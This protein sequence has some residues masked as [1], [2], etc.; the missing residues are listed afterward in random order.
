MESISQLGIMA[1]VGF[2]MSPAQKKELLN[3]I[4]ISMSQKAYWE[5]DREFPHSSI[6]E[7]D[8]SVYESYFLFLDDIWEKIN[9]ESES[10][11]VFSPLKSAIDDLNR[12]ATPLFFVGKGA[13][14]GQREMLMEKIAHYRIDLNA[15]KKSV[16]GAS[17]YKACDDGSESS[18]LHSFATITSLSTLAYSEMSRTNSPFEDDSDLDYSEGCGLD[19][20]EET[21]HSTNSV[22][23]VSRF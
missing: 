1:L 17:L 16:M 22:E 3:S 15:P 6:L 7:S 19:S 14:A 18:S 23:N 11:S 5:D 20:G 10:E 13:N 8:A 12:I 9:N 21:P 2:I 4:I